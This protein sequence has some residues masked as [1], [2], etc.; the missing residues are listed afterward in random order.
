MM[1]MI[2]IPT[3]QHQCLTATLTTP[4][5]AQSVQSMQ[6]AMTMLQSLLTSSSKQGHEDSR[7][8]TYCMRPTLT[9][10]GTC[11]HFGHN[12]A[13]YKILRASG[14]AAGGHGVLNAHQT[15]TAMH[16]A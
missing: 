1:M 16:N 3:K 2:K 7:S 10:A 13:S 9:A 14:A 12:T 4:A 6:V 11:Q 8:V 5:A 15:C